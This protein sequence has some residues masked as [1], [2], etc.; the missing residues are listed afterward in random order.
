MWLENGQ[1]RGSYCLTAVSFPILFLYKVIFSQQHNRGEKPD[2]R[3]G[4]LNKKISK[5]NY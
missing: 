3:N 1:N 4:F 5:M 2:F